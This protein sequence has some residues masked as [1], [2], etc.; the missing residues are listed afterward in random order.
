MSDNF[1]TFT[2]IVNSSPVLTE[3]FSA[4]V[5]DT[6]SAARELHGV[7]ISIEDCTAIAELRNATL[8]ATLDRDELDRQLQELPKLSD[9]KLKAD[10]AS[11]DQEA[12]ATALQK[13]NAGKDVVHHERSSD[14]RARRISMARELGIATPPPVQDDLR[15]RAEKIEL[16]QEVKNP[17]Q[18]VALA[19]KWGV[20]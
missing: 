7:D 9:S 8:G 11:G 15:S 17:A 2:N 4:L 16:L 6:I 3:R 19:R 1:E 10:I 18:R 14:D 20:L 12:M 13:V 5:Q